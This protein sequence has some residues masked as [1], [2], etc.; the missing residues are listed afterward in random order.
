[1]AAEDW[2]SKTNNR[3]DSRTV[4]QPK[5]HS[6]FSRIKLGSKTITVKGMMVCLQGGILPPLL[7]PMVVDE[8]LEKMAE[9]YYDVQGYA[10]DLVN[11][12][13]GRHSLATW[14]ENP[15]SYTL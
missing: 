9:A 14:E 6:Q 4:D 5:S 15:R 1:M 10:D 8:L 11:I 7:C 13:R 12:V 2:L 3:V